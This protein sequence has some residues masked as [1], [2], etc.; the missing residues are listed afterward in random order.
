MSNPAVYVL[1]ETKI[2]GNKIRIEDNLGEGIHIHIGDF[3]FALSIDEF[4]EIVNQVELAT[5][6]LLQKKGFS[7]NLFDKNALD[8]EWI[9]RY[10]E[11]EKIE[12]V[13]IKIK[14]L[15][16]KGESLVSPEIQEIVSVSESRQYK[17]LCNN[18]SELNRYI[19]KNDY[20][21]SNIERLNSVLQCIKKNGYPYD[22]KYILVN[23]YN[24]IYDGDHRAACLLM[25]LGEDA[26]IPVRKI[27][28]SGEKNIE[29]QRELIEK[30]KN[31][32]RE[33]EKTKIK[34][35]KKWSEELNKLDYN[36]SQFINYLKQKNYNFYCIDSGWSNDGNVVADRIIVLDKNK[37]IDFCKE[38]GV[39]YYGQSEFRY[40]NFLYSIQ[41]IVY[42]KL[43]DTK[44]FIS[45]CI[46]CKSKF[47]NAIMPLDKKIQTY[48]RNHIEN[49]SLD[50]VMQIL[51]VIVDS[52]I[53]SNCF[54]EDGIV[55][56][57][58][59]RDILDNDKFVNL[60]KTVF[61]GYTEKLIDYLKNNEYEKVYDEYIKND[62]Y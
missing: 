12:V 9:H 26:W 8:W 17:A 4:N 38:F 39:S 37:V 33:E 58:K 61:F 47:E 14:D 20:G 54:S 41:R 46:C 27:T 43:N 53:N 52:M 34:P 60:L 19:E 56:I 13:K 22:N 11:I 2:N 49:N 57:K 32:F 42:L 30:S 24:Q 51:Y 21:I 23:Q 45:D 44:V 31:S 62:E 5:D 18:H 25:L 1:G 15:L 36:Y 29:E 28:L 10:E 16:T 55:F 35:V 7:L 6:T 40:Y 59:N 50:T 48:C 3:R